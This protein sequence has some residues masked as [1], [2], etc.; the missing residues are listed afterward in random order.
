MFLVQDLNLL[1]SR[2]CF[3][4]LVTF[5][6]TTM[7][8]FKAIPGPKAWPGIG[9]LL[10]YTV[11]KKY[12]FTRLHET[13]LAKYKEF[14]PVVKEMV[15][16][17]NKPILWIFDPA[18]IN[19]LINIR[20]KYPARISHLALEH[21]RKSKPNFYSSGGLLPTNGETWRRLRMPAQKPMLSDF[22][23]DLIKVI[24]KA[25]LDF[26]ES[27]KSKNVWDDILEELKKHFL[28]IT[29]LVVLGKSTSQLQIFR[30]KLGHDHIEYFFCILP[31]FF[32]SIFMIYRIKKYFV[33]L[34]SQTLLDICVT[35]TDCGVK[36]TNNGFTPYVTSAVGFVSEC[37]HYMDP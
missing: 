4:L 10:D 1:A 23:Q 11:L 17:S 13:G 36:T 34:S 12:D 8:P 24:D 18:D 19:T 32:P 7:K 6:L 3:S 29:T 28:E 22:S 9:S 20:D 30:V 16:G 21:Y 27:L 35:N 31:C 15:V 26:V 37:S 14:G 25:S 33:T 5:V 2:P